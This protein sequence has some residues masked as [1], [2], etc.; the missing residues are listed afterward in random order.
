VVALLQCLALDSS[1]ETAKDYLAK[2]IGFKST[3]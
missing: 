3:E 1:I 2:V